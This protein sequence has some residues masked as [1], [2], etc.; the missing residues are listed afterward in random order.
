[1]NH[2]KSVDGGKAVLLVVAV[3]IAL[4]GAGA[5]IGMITASDDGPPETPITV[6][7]IDA[8]SP[9]ETA[10]LL[11]ADVKLA[12]KV[13][14]KQCFG[15]YGCNIEYEIKATWP[16]RAVGR[17]TECDVTYDVRGFKDPQTGTL[18]IRDD[19]TFR[20][21]TVFPLGVTPKSSTKPVAR[22]TEVECRS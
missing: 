12:V 5:V 15:S 1:M 14:D 18:T 13:T 22:V 21:G 10:V 16:L 9:V 11:A 19:G 3:L 20:D 8:P 6:P 17:G 7:T 4:C 2:S